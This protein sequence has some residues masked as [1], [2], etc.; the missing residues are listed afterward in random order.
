MLGCTSCDELF[1]PWLQGYLPV[2]GTG[3]R[4]GRKGNP[5]PNIYRQWC[6]AKAQAC[7]VIEQDLIG[8]GKDCVVVD[9]SPLRVTSIQPAV[10]VCH[11]LAEAAGARHVL[12]DERPLDA[13][14]FNAIT[15][16]LPQ[17]VQHVSGCKLD[18]VCVS[19]SGP[20]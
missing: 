3:Y 4:K 7:I 11:D 12:P 9:L 15:V 20:S 8:N 10:Q 19:T 6:D 5:L 14:P 1:C 13:V 18:M 17:S 16:E 2:R